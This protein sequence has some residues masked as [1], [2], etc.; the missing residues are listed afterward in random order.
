MAEHKL[1][2]GKKWIARLVDLGAALGYV[3]EREYD[4]ISRDDR[5]GPVDVAWF[6]SAEDRFPL[7]IFEVESVASGQMGH[8]AGKVF[9]QDTRLFEKPLFLFHLIVTG[10]KLSARVDVVEAAY[11]KFNYRVYGVAEGEA[12]AA[13]CDILSQHRRV[14]DELDVTAVAGCLSLWSEIDLNQIWIHAE[15]CRFR[16]A[17]LRAYSALALNDPEHFPRQLV[18]LLERASRGEAIEDPLGYGTFVGTYCCRA[19]HAGILADS[20]PSNGRA[21]LVDL[22]NWQEGDGIMKMAAP[23][24]GLSE[25]GDNFVFSLMPAIWALLAV[26]FRRTPGARSWI[27]KQMALVVAPEGRIRLLGYAATAV[28]MAH[29]AAAQN[30]H[31]T[32]YE[33]VRARLN[34]DGGINPALLAEPPTLAGTVAETD[35]WWEL[36]RLGKEPVPELAEFRSRFCGKGTADHAFPLALRFLREETP[37][38]AGAELRDLLSI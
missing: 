21:R 33:L 17:W 6:R 31:E 4:V 2:E 34:A 18:R 12:T 22:M 16:G 8:N 36:I 14:S 3:S 13:V 30:G 26:L 10:T 23:Y 5:D 20:C 1:S 27:L 24:P 37:P 15:E 32:Q 25:D 19:I 9:T 11:G 35:E 28:W 29:I 38:D 7:F